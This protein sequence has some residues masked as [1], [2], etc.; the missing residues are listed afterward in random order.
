MTIRHLHDNRRRMPSLRRSLLACLLAAALLAAGTAG[1][2]SANPS[3][4][5]PKLGRALAVAGL[6]GARRAA[7]AIDL[8]T[9]EILFKQLRY[10]GLEPASNEKLPVTFAA[11]KLL[12]GTYRI[13]T[14]VLGDG[15]QVGK[16]WRGNLV[17]RGR[18]DPTLASRDLKRLAWLV[19]GAGIRQVSGSVVGDESY[20]DSKRGVWGWKSYF[21]GGES[22]PLS[23]LTVDRCVFNG[24][25]SNRPALAAAALF[26]RALKAAGVKVTGKSRQGVAPAASVP[27][28]HITSPP[29]WKIL[30]YMDSWSDNFTAELVLKHLGAQQGHGTSAG[31]AAVVRRV[32]TEAGIPVAGVRIVDGSGLSSKDRLTVAA[33]VGILQSAW[34]DPALRKP[35]QTVLAVAGKTGTLRNRL[36]GVS[37]KGRVVAKTGTTDDASALAGY[38]KGRYA[39]AI[40]HN[41]YPLASWYAKQAE[42]RFVQVLAAAAK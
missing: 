26:K 35:F 14:D 34:A 18:G 2:R 41:G 24:Q 6:T 21:Y 19:R 31:G 37:T 32:L 3:P 29:L 27:I 5:T 11:L 13:S 15:G 1:A 42:D 33:L 17:L 30:R 9:G 4:L 40:L 38:V 10:V 39:F 28:A 25:L 20:F 16:V 36:L 8:K 22:P 7:V 12:G 23:A